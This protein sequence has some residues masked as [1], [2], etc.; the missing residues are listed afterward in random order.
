MGKQLTEEQFQACTKD[1]DVGDQTRA[2][3]YG[4]LVQGQPQTSFVDALGLT[5][6]AISQAVA[7]V[8]RAFEETHP[9]RGFQRVNVLL[10]EHQAFIVNKWAEDAKRRQ[11][12][13]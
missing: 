7:R 3:A 1:L 9:P 13:A 11:G 12:K 4:V 5:R 8:W 2:I 10:P 6:G